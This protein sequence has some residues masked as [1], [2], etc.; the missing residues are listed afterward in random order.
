MTEC[1]IM[2][3]LVIRKEGIP[4]KIKLT[5]DIKKAQYV[6]HAGSFHADDVFSTIFLG[7]LFGKITLFRANEL[8]EITDFNKKIIYDIGYGEFDHHMDDARIRSNGIKYSSFGLLWEKYGYDY[9]K[10]KGV[11]DKEL[12]NHFFLKDFI[13]QIDAF[14]NGIF[15]KNP[16]DYSISSL[17]SII[18]LCNPTWKETTDSNQAFLK[19]IELGEI[20]FNRIEQRILDKVAAKSFVEDA[21][22]ASDGEILI[23]NQYL[24]FM[25]FVLNS[26]SEKAS[27]LVFAIFPSNRGGYNVRA[28]NKELGHCENR[29]NFPSSWGGKSKEELVQLTEIQ[30][31]RFCHKNLFLCSC[32]TLEDALKISSLA[33]S[34]KK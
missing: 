22:N 7:K 3:M 10:E 5:K 29:L 11:E 16:K 4:M 19:A 33:L 9:L 12:A 18:E 20:I 25:D 26:T 17:A 1:V 15:P 6:T 24:P 27:R 31:F 21:I 32:D 13:M 23:L 8:D 14:D 2:S 34:Q 30:T 28:I